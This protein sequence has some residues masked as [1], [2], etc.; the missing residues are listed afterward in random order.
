MHRNAIQST[1]LKTLLCV[2]ILPFSFAVIGARTAQAGPTPTPTATPMATPTA[3]PTPTPTFNSLS[4]PAQAAFDQKVVAR[5]S[6][7]RA[8]KHVAYL[9]ETIGSRVA[10]MEAEWQGAA[11][12]ASALESLEYEVELQPFPAPDEYIGSVEL[13]SGA[14]WQM[15]AGRNGLIT[16]EAFVSGE[17]IQVSSGFR[18]S[19]FPP[20]TLGAIVLM[21]REKEQWRY[22]RQV[23]NAEAAGAIGVILFNPIR[24]PG[25]YGGIWPPDI[26]ATDIPVLGAT[27]NQGAWLDEMLEQGA[28]VLKVQTEHYENLESVNVIGIK[29][30]KDGD[31]A[32]DAVLVTAHFD[33]VI[34]APGANDNASGV[35][36]ALELAR[37]L[38]NY[39]TDKELRIILFGCEEPGLV[40][41]RYYA[42]QLHPAELDR[43]VGVFNSDMVATSDSESDQLYAM[44]VDG[45]SNLVTDVAE[46]AGSRLGN[47]SL[48]PAELGRSDHVPFH[49]R[50]VP[51]AMFARGRGVRLDAEDVYHTFQDT[52]AENIS[53]ERMQSALDIVGAAVFDLIRKEVP[54]LE[55][56][57]VR[58]DE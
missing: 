10:G 16:G 53:A 21:E 40:G 9:S 25:N 34:G 44:T 24:F 42:S 58:A 17:L 38:R 54:G 11:Y 32:A 55:R 5:L 41:S 23:Y 28:V 30:A 51:A 8:V 6:A 45:S 19:D 20:E 7:E 49:N 2:L 14:Q 56:S 3:A 26:D 50:G 36:L 35:G 52:V 22:R 43:I 13:P 31:L 57:R 27:W 37:V 39:N 18:P 15:T 4:Q 12:I 33:S 1:G 29:P 48:L 46:A 47:S